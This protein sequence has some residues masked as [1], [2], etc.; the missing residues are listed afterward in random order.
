MTLPEIHTEPDYL[1]ITRDPDRQRQ[2]ARAVCA[3]HAYPDP[4]PRPYA[5]GSLLVMDLGEDRVL[6]VFPPYEPDGCAREVGALR[7]VAGRLPVNTP[8]VLAT[9]ELAGW[10]YVVMSRL[11]GAPANGGWANRRPLDEPWQRLPRQTQLELLETVGRALAALHRLPTGSVDPALRIDWEAFMA[12]QR[13]NCTQR[14]RARG[15]AETWLEQVDD[16]LDQTPLETERRALLHTEVM[17][18]HVQLV[19]AQGSWSVGGLLD[20][21]PAMVG[22]PEYDLASV[23]VFL[24]G[25]DREWFDAFARGYGARRSP[26]LARR[27]L[28]WLL[29]H[30]YGDLAWAHDLLGVP[31]GITRLGDLAEAWWG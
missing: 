15:L 14:L 13:A 21:E 7:A 24:C 8:Q 3:H 30:R 29:L 18:D 1:A 19:E 28:A 16:F 4:T 2:I 31:A 5:G 10:P 22:E 11:P 20:F 23:G 27:I 25:S 6:K 17:R 26:A 9:G 12:Q